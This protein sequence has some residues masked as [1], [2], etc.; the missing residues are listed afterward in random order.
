M[1]GLLGAH[2]RLV[3]FEAPPFGLGHEE[4]G[5]QEAQPVGHRQND[6]RV[7]QTDARRIGRG[8]RGL[9]GLARVQEAKSAHYGARLAGGG[10]NTVGSGTEPVR[11]IYLALCLRW[12]K[13]GPIEALV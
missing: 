7:L 3:V 11:G 8:E 10:R 9:L 12:S 2:L 6:E 5:A 4:D 1:R 13:H